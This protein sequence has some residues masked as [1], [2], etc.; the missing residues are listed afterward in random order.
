MH[1]RMDPPMQ[2][3]DRQS[4]SDLAKSPSPWHAQPSLPQRRQGSVVTLL[5]A[6]VQSRSMWPVRPQR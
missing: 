3:F 4:L 6:L 2:A 1:A 5:A